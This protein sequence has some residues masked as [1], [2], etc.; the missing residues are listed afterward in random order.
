MPIKITKE[1][2]QKKFGQPPVVGQQP[3]KQ[4]GGFQ[5]FSTGFT[6]G[7][8]DSAIGTARTLQSGGQAAIAAVDSTRNYQQVK[9]QTG[10]KSLQ[11]PEAEQIDQQLKSKNSTETAG[12]VAAFGAELL[13]PTGSRKAVAKGGELLAEGA[14]PAINAGKKIVQEGVDTAKQIG[15]VKTPEE[16]VKDFVAPKVTKD[17]SEQAIKQGRVTEPGILKASKILPSKK[18][19]DLAEAVKDFVSPRKSVLENVDSLDKEIRRVNQGV[20]DYVSQNK[21]PFNTNQLRTKLNK[22][23]DELRVIFA[24]EKT[25]EKTYNAIVDEF[26]DQIKN[27]DTAGLLD[28][29]QFIDKIPSIKKLLDSQG[30]GENVK[31]EVVLTVRRMANEYIAELLPKGN[32]YKASLL[33]QT[34]M[35]EALENAAEK[36][37]GMIGKNNLQL[38]TERYPLLKWVVGGLAGSA[39]IGVG[40]ALIGS[41]D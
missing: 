32:P 38:L 35:I 41:T 2:Y 19:E 6:K 22:G 17:I 21:V 27:K 40:G 1:E 39:G 36:N 37:Q 20:K 18:D 29:R 10:F 34:K 4:G 8:L 7:L 11:G 31:R 12:K 30:L 26:V 3:T 33:K 5:D 25:A 28:T 13:T 24:S 15:R 9:E 23:K 16:F 14:S